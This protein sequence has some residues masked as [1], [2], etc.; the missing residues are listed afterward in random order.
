MH[1]GAGR[2][3]STEFHLNIMLPTVDRQKGQLITVFP[4][5]RTYVKPAMNLQC[6][7]TIHSQVT[8]F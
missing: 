3:G 5:C 8:F 1:C 2:K 7:V 4:Y 6:S